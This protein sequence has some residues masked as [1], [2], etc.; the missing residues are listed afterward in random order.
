MSGIEQNIGRG[1]EGGI[2]NNT[3]E[4]L[5]DFLNGRNPIHGY[6]DTMIVDRI[7]KT[8]AGLT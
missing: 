5:D 1:L 8:H 3:F 6:N 7:L 2:G 4:S